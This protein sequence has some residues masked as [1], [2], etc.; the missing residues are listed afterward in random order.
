MDARDFSI[1]TQTDI[2]NALNPVKLEVTHSVQTQLLAEV[3][4]GQSITQPLC[5]TNINSNHKA[6]DEGKA[7]RVTISESCRAIAIDNASLQKIGSRILMNLARKQLGA[8]YFPTLGI[9]TNVLHARMNDVFPIK[10]SV[11]VLIHG[12][13]F[14]QFSEK[15]QEDIKRITAGQPVNEVLKKIRKIPGVMDARVSFVGFGNEFFFPKNIKYIR[16]LVVYRLA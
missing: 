1:V 2:D 7:V 16:T 4:A 15:E 11:S 3:K 10:A 9:E 12:T 8:S 5:S 13:W 14:Y 6:G